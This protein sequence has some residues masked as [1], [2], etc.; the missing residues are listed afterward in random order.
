MTYWV[1]RSLARLPLP[2][3]YGLASFAA[4]FLRCVVGYRRKVVAANIERAFPEFSTTEREQLLID[5][6]RHF[7]DTTL[8]IIAGY[9]MPIA[10]LRERMV[11]NNP[12]VLEEASH[13]FQQSVIVMTLHQGNWEWMLYAANDHYPIDSAAV[14]KRLHDDSADRFSRESRSRFGAEPIEMR[15]AGRNVIKHR[16][17]PRFIFMVADQSPGKRERVHWTEFLNQP[18]AFFSGA[19]TLARATGFPVV[20]AAGRRRVRGHYQIDLTLITDD[21]KNMDESAIIERYARLTE[22]AIR[23]SP[24]EWLWSNRRWKHRRQAVAEADKKASSDK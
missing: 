17:R 19:A 18:T 23:Q 7:A 10:A 20:F 9:A 5:F 16:R 21:P 4:W 22:Q 2:V 1:Y 11:I 15:E 8:E 12:E 3:L 6:Y 24:A 13:H 14:Y